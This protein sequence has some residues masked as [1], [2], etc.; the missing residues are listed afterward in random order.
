MGRIADGDRK[1]LRSSDLRLD[2]LRKL[3]EGIDGV[4]GAND[5]RLAALYPS[6]D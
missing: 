3:T 5:A 1:A 6:G 2:G 4:H